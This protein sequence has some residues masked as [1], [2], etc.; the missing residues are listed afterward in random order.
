M[1]VRGM[2]SLRSFHDAKLMLPITL[3]VIL[4]ICSALYWR[5]RR[6]RWL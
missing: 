5:F 6:A 2:S 3:G 1:Y 4:T